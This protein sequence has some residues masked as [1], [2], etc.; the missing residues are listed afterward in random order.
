MRRRGAQAK[1][2]KVA[3]RQARRRLASVVEQHPD[4]SALK[5]KKRRRRRIA[6]A[7]ALAALLVASSCLSCPEAPTNIEEPKSAPTDA[8]KPGPAG[9]KVKKAQTRRTPKRAKTAPIVRNT[10]PAQ[11]PRT[12]PWLD[13]IRLQSGA[14]ASRLAR[15]F[16]SSPPGALRWSAS[17]DSES[18]VAS[19]S[20][21]A[22]VGDT[23]LNREQAGCVSDVLT[24]PAYRLP[25]DDE[26]GQRKISIIVEF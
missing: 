22:A 11:E 15:C 6:V 14:R 17:I 13:A 26:P 5:A 9:V 3:L 8:V 23:V 1:A 25:K 12:T 24:Q 2:A 4:L 18:G 7:L 21:V 16:E 10:M 20:E 19:S